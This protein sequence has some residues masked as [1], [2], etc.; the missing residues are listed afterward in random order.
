MVSSTY[1][2]GSWLGIVRSGSVIVL[3]GNTNPAIVNRLWDF[4]GVEPTIHGVLNQVT[5]EFGTGLTGLPSFAILVQSDKLH[6]ILRGDITLIA[7]QGDSAEVVSGREV[8]TW[9]ERSLALPEALELTLADTSAGETELELPVGEAVV[10][11]Q[12][13]LQGDLHG[14]KTG[15]AAAVS[16]P[17]G[18]AEEESAAVE[19]S[20]ALA[21][22]EVLNPGGNHDAQ[23]SAA[24]YASEDES[25]KF[26]EQPQAEEHSVSLLK[27]DWFAPAEEPVESAPATDEAPSNVPVEDADAYAS[28]AMAAE[29]AD[30][31]WSAQLAPVSATAEESHNDLNLT[32]YPDLHHDEFTEQVAVEGSEQEP[33]VEAGPLAAEPLEQDPLEADPLEADPLEQEQLEQEQLM[34]EYGVAAEPVEVQEAP[35]SPSSE[36][37]SFTTNYDHLWGPTISRSVEDAAVRLDEN[38]QP[39]HPVSS[40]PVVPPLPPAPPLSGHGED[41]AAGI[42]PA[43]HDPFGAPDSEGGAF[44]SAEQGAQHRPDPG[45]QH[46]PDPGAQHNPD[47]GAQH[48]PDPGAQHNSHSPMIDSVPWNM[49]PAVEQQAPPATSTPPAT[50]APLAPENVAF[51]PD[52]DGHTIMSGEG[53]QHS[54]LASA[55]LLESRPS[56]GPMVLARMCPH[57]HAN[58]PSRSQCTHCGASINSEP[59]EV[60]RPRLGTMHIS[61]GESVELDHSLIIGRQ[62]S[63]SR[64]MGGAMPRLV[65][66]K[67]G[68]DDISRSHVEV[69]LDGWDVLLVDLK[70]TNGTVL[71]REGQAPRRLS[72]GEEAILLNGD[73]AELGDGISLLFDGLL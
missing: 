42:L 65:Q 13:L 26:A 61:S 64:V 7:H 1:R 68:N 50:S 11:L 62:P 29:A 18:L 38:G 41:P 31:E 58:P 22:E 73:I 52:H 8:S 4:L 12:R 60:G 21:A 23:D 6:A 46:N 63:V 69:R 3:E 10:R 5:A 51:D 70:A 44:P 57:G 19:A 47:P 37:E 54:A 28:F 67:S 40:D 32:R 25:T 9:S 27:H 49:S 35:E 53:Q 59:R 30:A 56:T 66:V 48:N 20:P 16:A 24:D 17:E 14:T 2:T 45:A 15:F 43:H 55:P 39:V 34:D 71:V 33:G 72:Q 36:E